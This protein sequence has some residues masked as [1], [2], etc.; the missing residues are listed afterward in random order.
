MA[1]E[2][3][4][5]DEVSLVQSYQSWNDNLDGT[6]KENW[7]TQC[8]SCCYA[9]VVADALLHLQDYQTALQRKRRLYF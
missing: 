3:P 9:A 2:R 5:D 7:R 4:L 1:E 6:S 8:R